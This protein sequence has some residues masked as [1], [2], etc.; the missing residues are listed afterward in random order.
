MNLTI[1]RS[2]QVLSLLL[3]LVIRN[4]KMRCGVHKT[5]SFVRRCFM[6]VPAAS[7]PL[8]TATTSVAEAAAAAP[9]PLAAPYVIVSNGR[10]AVAS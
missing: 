5:I 2:R 8:S 7:V 4:K 3:I 1:S 9:A 6:S 10:C